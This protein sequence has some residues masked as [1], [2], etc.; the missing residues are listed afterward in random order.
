LRRLR[1]RF[2]ISTG[3]AHSRWASPKESGAFTRAARADGIPTTYR[4]FGS[5]H[6]HWRAEFHAGLCW[7]FGAPGV[8]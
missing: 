7:S 8:C 3:P 1:I 4:F 2:F 5:R 6:G